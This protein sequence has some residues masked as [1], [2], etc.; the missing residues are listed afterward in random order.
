M[1]E[2]LSVI[3]KNRLFFFII[4]LILFE[5]ISL[6]LKPYSINIYSPVSIMTLYSFING[7]IS[8][9]QIIMASIVSTLVPFIICRVFKIVLK[10]NEIVLHIILI[11]SVLTCMSV[12]K[13]VFIPALAYSLT[14]YKMLPQSK[15]TFLYS[16]IFATFIIV[17]LCTGVFYILKYLAKTDLAAK[18]LLSKITNLEQLE[19]NIKL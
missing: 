14:A 11:F 12:L 10:L 5:V 1:V 7:T 9:Y 4:V 16:Y 17:I 6:T 15:I 18:Y 8:I 19:K 13:C 2:A 3:K